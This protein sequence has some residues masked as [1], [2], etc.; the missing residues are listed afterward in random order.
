MRV[1]VIFAH[2]DAVW[3]QP[4]GLAVRLEQARVLVRMGMVRPRNCNKAS[5]RNKASCSSNKASPRNCNKASP[6]L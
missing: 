2:T 5:P 1:L 6:L 4:C 3:Q